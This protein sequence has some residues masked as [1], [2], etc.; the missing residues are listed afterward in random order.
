MPY[1]SALFLNF[2]EQVIKAIEHQAERFT[3]II[4]HN[5]ESCIIELYR[6]S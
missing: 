2:I 6:T 3:E 4:Y 1:Q 5:T